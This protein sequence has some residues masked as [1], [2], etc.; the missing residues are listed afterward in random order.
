MMEAAGSVSLGFRTVSRWGADTGGGTTLISFIC[1]GER[2]ISRLT[3]PGAGGMTLALRAGAERD[4]S[5]EILGAG[6]TMLVLSAGATRAFS[7]ETLGAGA[8]T[9]GFSAGAASGWS[10]ETLGAG[11]ITD[12]R[13]NVPRE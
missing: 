4:L 2:E 7:R 13:E 12:P 5:R 9:F 3:V 6:A 11:G 10:R 1:T 8:I